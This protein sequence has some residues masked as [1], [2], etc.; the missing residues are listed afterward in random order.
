MDLWN[1]ERLYSFF[2]WYIMIAQL[3]IYGSLISLGKQQAPF[4]HMNFDF[5]VTLL[6][7]KLLD[8]KQLL[9]LTL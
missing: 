8:L 9:Q 7:T 5:F 1:T 6:S 3:F 2:F 4:V